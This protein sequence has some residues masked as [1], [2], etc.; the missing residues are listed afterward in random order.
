MPAM[1]TNMDDSRVEIAAVLYLTL[2][3]LA[4]RLAAPLL[5]DFPLNDGG[6]FHAMIMDAQNNNFILPETTT[7]NSAEIPFVYPPLALY[8]TALLSTLTGIDILDLLRILPPVFSG[9]AIPAFYILAREFTRT[10]LQTILAVLA[11]AFIPRVFEWHV[12]GGGITRAPGFIFAILTLV[13]IL[14]LYR[15]GTRRNLLLSSVF[16]ALTILTHPDAAVQMAISAGIFYLWLN[17]S[18]RGML[19]SFLAALGAIVLSAPWWFTA[20]LRHSAAPFQAAISAV[21]ADSPNLIVR[22]FVGFLFDFTDEPYLP[23]IAV[24]ALLGIFI[25]IARRDLLTIAWM[26]LLYFLKPRGSVLYMMMPLALLAG[27]GLEST[28]SNVFFAQTAS[29]ASRISLRNVLQHKTARWFIAFVLVYSLM[30]AFATGEK[31]RQDFTLQP[32]DLE[33]MEWIRANAPISASFAVITGESAP[34]HDPWSEWFPMIAGRTSLATIFGYE[35]VSDGRFAER[36]Q[37]YQTLQKCAQGDM[38]CLAVWE[39]ENNLDFSYIY[40]QLDNTSLLIQK[41]LS[42]AENYRLIYNTDTAAIYEKVK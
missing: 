5:S 19:N 3:G 2:L 18:V 37:R 11:F 15:E 20:I 40:L 26:F 24:F 9:L 34:F 17:R 32:S 42:E 36:I 35:W 4:I 39:S 29:P 8:L 27:L 31:L 16:G 13:Y 38:D 7:Y 14:R 6:L 1:N 25:S 30:S 33:A 22:I 12:T 23:L 21:V 10:K 41:N 28:I